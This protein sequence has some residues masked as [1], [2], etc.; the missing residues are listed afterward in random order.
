M[1]L[2]AA[3]VIGLGA[4]T[5]LGP[6]V[7]A[8]WDG[9]LAG[10]SGVRLL[11]EEW[12]AGLPVRLAA[13]VNVDLVESI[14]RIAARRLDR[15]QQL[16]LIAA[17][18]AW[19]H[20]GSPEVD[21]DRLAVVVGTG[22]G[23]VTTLLD[24]ADVLREQGARLISPFSVPMLMANGPAAAVGL[25]LGARAGV[26]APVSACASGAEALAL[27]LD[28]LRLGRADVVVCGGTEAAVHPLPLAGF[29]AMRALST[30]E[31]EPEAASRPYDKARDG[32]VL[33]EGAGIVVLETAEHA[34]ARGAT[35]HAW[36]AGSGITAD[37]HHVAQPD[38]AGRGASRAITLSLHDA[39]ASP[40]DI[41][42][43]NAHATSTPAGDIAEALAVRSALGSAADN[44]AISAI[45]SMTGHLLGA[46]GAVEAVTTILALSNRLAPAIRNLDDPD[47]DV[48][49]DLVRVVAR[50]LP[51]QTAALCTSFGFGGHDVALLFR[52]AA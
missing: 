7:S 24:S 45:K 18:E 23:G 12:A 14:G 49:L 10:R 35:V 3:A 28:L 8:L 40:G 17:R 38:P 47:D 21:P 11:D 6:D 43:L 39:D 37:S 51:A 13:T 44:V 52:S 16:A 9:V 48:D 50:Q 4:I 5:P 26:H 25:E 30:R 20:A 15:S 22:I 2:P 27:G 29:A 33:G 36:F 19:A 41:R 32:F 46:A 31:S 1:T 42:H 34:Q